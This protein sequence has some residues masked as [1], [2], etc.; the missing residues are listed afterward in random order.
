MMTVK[1]KAGDGAQERGGDQIAM[2]AS[3]AAQKKWLPSELPARSM[4]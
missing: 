2:P 1:F 3:A 4:A